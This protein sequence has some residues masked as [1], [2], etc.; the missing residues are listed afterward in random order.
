MRVT[1]RFSC[2][3]RSE[4]LEPGTKKEARKMKKVMDRKDLENPDCSSLTQTRI[5]SQK[6]SVDS[7]KK[8]NKSCG[9][10]VCGLFWDLQSWQLT[11]V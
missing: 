1:F 6:V 4:S 7:N 11:E 10:D 5:L 9:Q 2:L 8:I 3:E